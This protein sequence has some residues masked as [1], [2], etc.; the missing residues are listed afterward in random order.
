M[1]RL[2]SLL[3]QTAERARA[4]AASETA[5]TAAAVATDP[6]DGDVHA[7]NV[8]EGPGLMKRASQAAYRLK[9][10]RLKVEQ[11]ELDYLIRDAETSGDREA[12]R[13]LLRRK[14]HILAQRHTID[15]ATS[16]Q[17]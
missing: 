8:E 16:L 1:G 5:V 15:E 13:A 10:M 6:V 9:R 14:Q 7:A 11:A 17:A 2:D 12:L 3:R 4:R